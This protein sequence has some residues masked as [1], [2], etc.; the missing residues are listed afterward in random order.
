[1]SKFFFYCN[2]NKFGF[3]G[4]RV[5]WLLSEIIHVYWCIYK[6][7][8][9]CCNNVWCCQASVACAIRAAYWGYKDIAHSK[10]V[11][12]VISWYVQ[13][14]EGYPIAV[15]CV[16]YTTCVNRS[17][18]LLIF[19][20]DVRAHRWLVSPGDDRTLEDVLWINGLQILT[21]R[22][23]MQLQQWSIQKSLSANKTTG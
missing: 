12:A 1:M 17:D 11:E 4:L 8:D 14:T 21:K 7:V 3:G 16:K 15:G 5:L 18:R 23:F 9:R 6:M 19:N 13:N 20:I 10:S 2:I 22:L